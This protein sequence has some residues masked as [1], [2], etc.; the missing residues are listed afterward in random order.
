MTS[1]SMDFLQNLK[2]I[3]K[4]LKGE[5]DNIVDEDTISAIVQEWTGIPVTRMVE[6][7]KR[8]L[9]NLE[10]EIHKRLVDYGI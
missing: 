7:E 3:E 10:N 4:H 1:F 8:K 6:D 2:K 9:A 5:M